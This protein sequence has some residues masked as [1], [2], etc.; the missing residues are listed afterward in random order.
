MYIPDLSGGGGINFFA[1]SNS[2]F[3]TNETDELQP[4][5]SMINI[6]VTNKIF[7]LKI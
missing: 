6:T 7:F 5:K 3:D 4:V 1:C 2:L